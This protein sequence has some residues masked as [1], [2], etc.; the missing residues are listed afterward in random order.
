MTSIYI[1]NQ[2][3]LALL[4]YPKVVSSQYLVRHLSFL[5]NNLACNLGLHWI[6]SHSKVRG[7]EK[8]DL[9]AKEVA[10]GTLSEKIHLPHILRDPLPYSALVARQVYLAK[11]RRNW[12]ALWEKSNRSQ[13]MA[14]IDKKFP[15]MVSADKLTIYLESRPA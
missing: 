14:E 8:V 2:A 1:D 11:L 12:E 15:S 4:C 7:N 10:E 9:L 5:A 6:S 3:V 13:R